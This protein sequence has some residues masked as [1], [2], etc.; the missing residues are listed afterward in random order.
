MDGYALQISEAE[1]ARYQVMASVRRPRKR[2][3]GLKRESV[4][5]RG[6]PTWAAV[7]PLR[8]H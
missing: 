3:C 6:S 4:Q 8:S 7:R 1:I 5:A 2:S